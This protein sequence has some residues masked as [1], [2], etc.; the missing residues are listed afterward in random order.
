[1][2]AGERQAETLSDLSKPTRTLRTK[3]ARAFFFFFKLWCRCEIRQRANFSPHTANLGRREDTRH[4]EKYSSYTILSWHQFNA[5]GNALFKAIFSTVV[6]WDFIKTRIICKI[7]SRAPSKKTHNW[8]LSLQ[9]IN[10]QWHK[11]YGTQQEGTHGW[12]CRYFW[13]PKTWSP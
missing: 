10:V 12:Q 5:G 2:Q 7:W 13:K 1:M 9:K 3:L 8:H 11:N 6:A 4:F